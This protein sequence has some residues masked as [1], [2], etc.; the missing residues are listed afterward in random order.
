MT[1]FLFV[2]NFPAWNRV[3]ARNARIR[4]PAKR[5][6]ARSRKCGTWN[7]GL[8]K[9]DDPRMMAISESV[10]VTATGRPGWSKGLTKETHPSLAIVSVKVSRAQK[11]KT[12]ND[13]QRAGLVHGRSWGKGRTKETCPIVAARSIRRSETSKGIPNPAH[14]ERMKVFYAN[15]PDKHPN[16]IVARKTKGKGYTHIERILAELL[17]E[18]D[19]H[20][21]FNVRIGSKW[22]DFSAESHRLIFE[23][24]GEHWHKDA[25]KENARDNYL[26]SLGWTVIHFTGKDLVNE[27]NRCR[28][29][30]AKA[31]ERCRGGQQRFRGANRSVR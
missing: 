23:A 5:N 1:I 21:A 7:T 11:G 24:D 12:I 25:S 14:S 3:I 9:H 13:A 31:L 6:T 2:D 26:R 30:I 28:G 8:T 29:E 15:N 27:T 4:F 19:V 10:R 16:S 22:P 18:T 17:R 20:F